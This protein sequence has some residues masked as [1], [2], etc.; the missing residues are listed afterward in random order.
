[1]DENVHAKLSQ[2]LAAFELVGKDHM[3]CELC[4]HVCLSVC[5]CVFACV[6]FILTAHEANIG[7]I[8]PLYLPIE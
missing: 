3:T 2:L 7:S 8:F 6:S 4:V 1:M 5:V